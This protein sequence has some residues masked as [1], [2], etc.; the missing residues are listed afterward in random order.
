MK[1][2]PKLSIVTPSLNQG[3]YI[4]QTI[5]S[6]LS[7]EGDF[8]IDYIISDGGSTDNSIEIIKKYGE[9]LKTKKYHIKCKGISY[10]WWS[11]KDNGQSHAINKGFKIA[12]GDILAWINSDDYYEPG[13]F[14]FIMGKFKEN[15]GVDL[16]YGD[17]RII[18]GKAKTTKIS[19]QPQGTLKKLLEGDCFIF[20]PSSFFTKKILTN[21][22]FLNENLHYAMD[23]DL[24]I[25]IFKQ[26][27]ALHFAKLLSNFRI[28]ENSK[29]GSQQKQFLSD[30]KK[31]FKKY[32]GNIIRRRTICKIKNKLPGIFFFEKQFPILYKQIKI[33]FYFF[34]NKLKYRI[35]NNKT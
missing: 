11:E 8:Y 21:V 10:R 27:R 24:W 2:Y 34:I 15:P 1:K 20:Q 22:E 16:I 12:K 18:N 32:G 33:I 26:G 30:R 5:K 29:S 25:K 3:Q 31:I 19:L 35:K 14:E 28:W 7:Q 9:L 13:A 6:V 17:G 4:E 23:Y